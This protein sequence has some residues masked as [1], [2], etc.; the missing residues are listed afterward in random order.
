MSDDE[1][2]IPHPRERALLLG[3]EAAEQAL[4]DAYNSG[5]LPHAWLISGPRGI[6]K[7]TL[8]YRFARFLL[9]GGGAGGLFGPPSDLAVP[10]DSP[11]FRRVAS[12]SHADL[13]AV[14]REINDKTGKLRSEIVVDG[15]RDLSQFLRLTPSEG[16]WRIAIVD[17]AD[18]MNRN[19]ANALLKILEEPPDRAVL[20]VVS[21]APGRLLP[22]IR[23]RCR[24][25]PLQPLAE[26]QVLQIL[27]E[28]APELPAEEQV[29]LARLSGGSPGRALELAA[30]GSIELFRAVSALLGSLPRLDLARLHV[31]A[32]RM[33]RPGA[34]ADF[35]TL[36]FVLSWWLETM[37]RARARGEAP[38]DV[39]PGDAAIRSKLNAAASLDRWVDVW[40]KIAQLFARA[41][42]VNLDRKQV[43]L[44]S[45]LA[46]E[47]AARL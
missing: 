39:L 24:K 26:D 5:R 9:A 15:V 6:G 23:S 32:D 2:P 31:L 46:L 18:E 17:A 3:H 29:A 16:G 25:L 43:V 33:A 34:D 42:A 11:V 27:G 13:R 22:T 40:E 35:R 1:N 44:G 8:A 30:A 4:L 21:H 37:V 41:D 19:A 20:L 14:E 38:V 47:A 28:L 36:G 12:Q 45:F 10:A 7:A